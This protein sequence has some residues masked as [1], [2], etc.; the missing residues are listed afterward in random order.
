MRAAE[1]CPD[2]VN[3]Q[4]ENTHEQ[5]QCN[6]YKIIHGPG[7]T[8]SGEPLVEANDP[9]PLPTT[10]VVSAQR[11]QLCGVNIRVCVT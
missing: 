1:T 7:Y 5:T 8:V 6:A 2:R 3:K 11:K 9:V 10:Q 4:C